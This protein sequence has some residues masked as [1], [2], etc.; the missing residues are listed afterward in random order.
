MRIKS[1]HVN[2]HSDS[3]TSK[4]H[5]YNAK[6]KDLE[7]LKFRNFFLALKNRFLEVSNKRINP[8]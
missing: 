1:L 4:F 5:Y 3:C 8:S 7:I 2:R 6:H